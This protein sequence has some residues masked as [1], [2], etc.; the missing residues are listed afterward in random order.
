MA[1]YREQQLTQQ[2]LHIKAAMNQ[3]GAVLV[4]SVVFEMLEQVNHHIELAVS[5]F[6]FLLFEALANNAGYY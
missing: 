5:Y 1:L 6:F 2:N 3:R 4:L